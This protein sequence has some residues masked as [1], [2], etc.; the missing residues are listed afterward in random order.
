MRGKAIKMTLG[1][2]HEISRLVVAML[3]SL[4]GNVFIRHFPCNILLRER[5]QPLGRGRYT[6]GFSTIAVDIAHLY[7][8]L[9]NAEQQEK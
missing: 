2:H 9:R 3:H 4:Y 6:F 1:R 7:S 5:I 8:L